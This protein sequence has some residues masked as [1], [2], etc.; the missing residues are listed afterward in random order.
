MLI[1][2]CVFALCRK[3]DINVNVY[4]FV[5]KMMECFSLSRAPF[6]E[7]CV[8]SI[9]KYILCDHSIRRH[10]NLIFFNS[11]IDSFFFFCMEARG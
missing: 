10:P 4:I 3:K 8:L 11:S 5:L 6:R 1:Y 2:F 7:L 9:L